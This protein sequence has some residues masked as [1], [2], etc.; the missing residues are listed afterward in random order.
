MERSRWEVC[1]A[2][3]TRF[4]VPVGP[5][6]INIGAVA[7][8]FIGLVVGLCGLGLAW[9]M[10]RGLPT[11]QHPNVTDASDTEESET[12]EDKD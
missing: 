7:V 9:R 1:D 2:R 11:D 10:V 6:T 8:T 12:T 4:H 3:T 5:M